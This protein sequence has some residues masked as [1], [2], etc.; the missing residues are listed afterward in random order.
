M[1]SQPSTL[2]LE[3]S[4]ATSVSCTSWPGLYY[5]MNDEVS[6]LGTRVL[7]NESVGDTDCPID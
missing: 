6:V 4:A 2:R 1:S 7:T 5:I 3:V